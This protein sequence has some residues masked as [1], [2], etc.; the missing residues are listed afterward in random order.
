M[1]RKIDL[2]IH[3]T[4]SDGMNNV[5]EIIELAK[6]NDIGII[7]LTDHDSIS[8][9]ARAVQLGKQAGI[10]V[11]PGVEIST[12]YRN[13]LLHILG[14][15]VD[16]E[17]KNFLNFLES[18]NSE[19]KKHFSL[20]LDRLN[21][22]LE[23]EGRKKV[24]SEKYLTREDKYFSL[25]GIASYI[26]KE[27]S[28]NEIQESFDFLVDKLKSPVLSINPQMAF[29]AI[30]KAGGL[31]FLAHSLAP[32]VSMRKIA[33]DSAEWKKIISEFKD[34]G[35]DGIECYGFAHN[36]GEIKMIIQY[37]EKYNLLLSG[38]SDWHG[39]FKQQG[40]DNIKKFL[41][42]YTGNFEGI[43]VSEKIYSY[44]SEKIIFDK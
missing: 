11:I 42:F 2:H 3:S 5:M 22:E 36:E 1:K 14:Y 41:P 29:A 8:G 26:Y 32:R 15:F 39:N 24:D 18:I 25:P 27:G 21:I 10:K 16:I 30:R 12:T 33:N 28:F 19:K 17:N 23:K 9:V 43:K 34:Q 6:K 13:K 35:L 20:E 4:F 44:F 37:S 38:G 31:S 40:G 7:S